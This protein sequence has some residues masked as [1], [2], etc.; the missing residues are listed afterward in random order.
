MDRFDVSALGV[1]MLNIIAVCSFDDRK[2]PSEFETENSVNTIAEFLIAD[3][4]FIDNIK[5]G[6]R[7]M[8]GFE[9]KSRNDCT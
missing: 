5:G 2:N 6:F 9:G 1:M 7:L 4:V 3:D 8:C